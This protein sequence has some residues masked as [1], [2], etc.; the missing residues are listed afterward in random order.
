[1][2]APARRAA[3]RASFLA[4]CEQYFPARFTLPWAAFHHE[5]AA[6][7]QRCATE[8]GRLA[9]ALPRGSGKTTLAQC[10]VLWAVLYGLRRYV[11]LVHAS[12]DLAIPSLK[13]LK[14]ELEGNDLLFED[15]PEVCW[16]IRQ[17]E[18][19]ASRARMQTVGGASTRME[20]SAGGVVLPTVEGSLASGAVFDTVGITGSVRGLVHSGPE[21]EMMRPDLVLVD[22]V[23]TRESSKSPTQT[24]DRELVV[25]GDLMGL[26]GPGKALA[27]AMLCTVIYPGDLSDRF[28]DATR[29]PEWNGLRV[30]MLE[31]M[32]AA[33]P[34]WNDYQEARRQALR[35]GQDAEAAGNAFYR[36]RRA[37]MDEGA[38]VSWP[39]R[40]RPGELSAVQ[41]AM[42]LYLTDPRTFRAEY[43][44][45][46]EPP[47]VPGDYLELT[48]DQVSA[49]LNRLP[50]GTAPRETT[51]VTAAIDVQKGGLYWLA[52]AWAEDFSG[53]VLDYGTFPAQ[54][55]P[56]YLASDLRPSFDDLFPALPLEA[57]IYAALAALVGRLAAHDFRGEAGEGLKVERIF[58]D[59]QWG[60]SRDAIYKFVRE[61]GH[62]GL[63]LP[64]HG[65]GIP[66]AQLAMDE[67]HFDPRAGQRVG[68]GW[69]IFPADAKRGRHVV[70]DTNQ[71]KSFLDE[72]LRVPPGG[73][74][75]LWLFGDRPAEH[76]LLAD[77]LTAEYRVKTFGRGREV[78]SWIRRPDRTENH[79]WDALVLAAAAASERGLAW[80]PGKVAEVGPAP[81][82]HRPSWRERAGDRVLP[83]LG[84]ARLPPRQ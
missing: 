54:T 65:R 64:S 67:W 5:A 12:D 62:K 20:W 81:G 56:Y 73:K 19:S 35:A 31:A 61:G 22:D 84:S 11:V 14:A 82:P 13:G 7:L 79:W 32:P 29:H 33:T 48:A 36:V 75:G 55:R 51:R 41:S 15:F 38:K 47:D 74:S 76:E 4:F 66:A 68:M 26:A 72:R 1:V 24:T 70:I 60:E 44:N 57:R 45:D 17:L 63:V 28:L 50:R 23:Q 2:K 9:L 42:N 49:R 69:K 83:P 78:D 77:H 25:T 52:C 21:G 39:D 27:C 40:K 34:L 18:R 71:W 6:R 59:S 58:I 53:A 43:Q 80:S 10:A 16:P 37:E 3:C 46:P 8:G 30:K